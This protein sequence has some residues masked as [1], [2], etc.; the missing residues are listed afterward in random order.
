MKSRSPKIHHPREVNSKYLLSGLLYCGKCKHKMVG[1]SAKSGK[2]FYYA[3]SNYLKRGKQ[4]CNAKMINKD[5]LEKAIVDRIKKHIITEKN[6]RELLSILNE[7]MVQDRKELDNQLI[8]I[9]KNLETLKNKRDKL[10]DIIES[11]KL[12]IDDIAPR[13]KDLNHQIETQERNHR[14]TLEKIQSPPKLDFSLSKLKTYVSD[15]KQL[16]N[17]GSIIEQKSFIQSFVKRIVVNQS[18]IKIEYTLPIINKID[19]TSTKEVLSMVQSGSPYWK[20]LEL[21]VGVKLLKNCE[22]SIN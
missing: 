16:L 21:F 8:G 19:R 13:L 11:G 22:I 6:L 5:L 10:Y 18:K 7:E 20:G 1:C 3:C 2:N 17:E 9:K 15:L 4:I 12:E 14:E